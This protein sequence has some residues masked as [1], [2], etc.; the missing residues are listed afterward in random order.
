VAGRSQLL[1][2][3]YLIHLDDDPVDLVVDRVA[4]LLP[5]L[6]EGEHFFQ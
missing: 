4:I 3:G 6:A 1:L 5:P 2:K